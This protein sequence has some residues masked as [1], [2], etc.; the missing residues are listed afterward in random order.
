MKSGGSGIDK[1]P[2]QTMGDSTGSESDV[3]K[4]GS[5]SFEQQLE[6]VRRASDIKKMLIG[7]FYFL[8]PVFRFILDQFVNR[9]SSVLVYLFHPLSYIFDVSD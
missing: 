2:S 9:Y 1:E 6:A 4:P 5:G 7:Q 8:L 3:S